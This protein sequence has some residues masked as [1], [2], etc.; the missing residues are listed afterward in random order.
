MNDSELAKREPG[1]VTEQDEPLPGQPA[2]DEPP[3]PPTAGVA[4]PQAARRGGLLVGMVAILLALG[5][6]AG[7]YL[8]WQQLEAIRATQQQELSRL[9]SRAGDLQGEVDR[10][11]GALSQGL[12][13]ARQGQEAVQRAVDALQAAER[14][15]REDWVIAEAGHLMRIANDTLHL[16]R[17]VDTAIAA[18]MAA[19]VR[20]RDLGDP[21]FH[22]VREPLAREIAALRAVAVPDVAG[23]TL[24]LGSLAERVEQI[25]L[26]M[27]FHGGRGQIPAAAEVAHPAPDA[28]DWRA[29]LRNVWDDLKSLVVIRRS[30]EPVG[31]MLPPDQEYF[32]RQN[33]RL[34]LEAA[35]LAA[36]RRNEAAYGNSLQ[37]ARE[38]LNAYFDKGAGAVTAM[39]TEIDRLEQAR[40]NP[41]LPDIS[42]SLRALREA[43]AGTGAQTGAAGQP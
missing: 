43:A 21:A 28:M 19:D 12:A 35:Q 8:V 17:D 2:P 4:P 24:V 3:P 18:L 38:W 33:L 41:P 13:G 39:L 32:L 6:G 42:G 10:L 16:Q 40:L 31:A 26:A 27:Q 25:P 7:T 20:L 36:L 15:G 30:K 37:T 5:A 22:A 14:R 29:F 1:P 23:L 9:A 34:K 11:S